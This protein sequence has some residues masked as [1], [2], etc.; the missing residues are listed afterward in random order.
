MLMLLTV[1]YVP[2]WCSTLP[3]NTKTSSPWKKFFIFQEIKLF[4]FNFYIFL[5]IKSC[6]FI[7]QPQKLIKSNPPPPKKNFLY[8]QKLNFLSQIL[9]KIPYIFS[10]ESFS[11]IFSEES[12]SYISK[13]EILQ[14]SAQALKKKD[15]IP[16]KFIVLQETETLKEIS[17]ISGENLYFLKK[18]LYLIF[19]IRIFFI[20]IFFIRIIRRNFFVVSNKIWLLLFF[21]N[22]FTFF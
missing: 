14:F 7:P 4:C 3:K 9:Q 13:N 6:N 17:D 15:L 20:R 19:F 11:F 1:S 2:T 5:E 12:I 16:G 8:L 18:V 21:N 22:I 10:K